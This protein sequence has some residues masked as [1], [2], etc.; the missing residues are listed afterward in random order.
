VS[1]PSI[2]RAWWTDAYYALA[3][4]TAVRHLHNR[5]RRRRHWRRYGVDSAF[6]SQA[7]ELEV[8]GRCYRSCGYCPN[9]Y[10][11][12]PRGLM[13][14]ELFDKIVGEL[15]A[16]RYDGRVSYHFYG[17]PL[18]DRRLPDLVTH[19]KRHL[20]H[21]FIEVYN[22]GDLLD[23]RTFREFMARGLDNF[24]SGN[25]VLCCNDYFETD[26]LGNVATSGLREVW[27]S[28]R[29]TALREALSRGD[30]TASVLCRPRDYV[31][32]PGKAL[33]IVPGG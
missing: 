17:E 6:M 1:A 28:E 10:A 8:N 33:R 25:V 3:R 20:P 16:L 30:R 29:F 26:V 18:L 32:D 15:A 7:V 2:A 27:T 11:A 21:A 4:S 24:L 19:T 5:I 12:R 14:R 22:N 9:S 23:L 31:P 13:A